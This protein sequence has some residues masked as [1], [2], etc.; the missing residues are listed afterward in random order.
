MHRPKLIL[1]L[2]VSSALVG[3]CSDPTSPHA[4]AGG[5]QPLAALVDSRSGGTQGFFFLPPLAP[6]PDDSGGF[7]AGRQPIVE[8]CRLDVS[9]SCIGLVA[10]FTTQSTGSE[11]IRVDSAAR[12]YHAQWNTANDLPLAN[13]RISVFEAGSQL[14]YADMALVKSIKESRAIP[15]DIKPLVRGSTLPIKFSLSA[16]SSNP[17]VRLEIHPSAFILTGAGDVEQLSVRAYDANG[18]MTNAPVTWSTSAP[19]AIG[20]SASGIATAA[21]SS[22]SAQIVAHSGTVSSAPALGVVMRPPEGAI[23]IGDANVVTTAVFANPFMMNSPAVPSIT[24]VDPSAPYGPGWRYVVRLTGVTP[25]IGKLLLS[26]GEAPVAGRIVSFV[27]AGSDFD[28]TVELVPIDAVFAS[29]SI[30][31][32]IPMNDIT[33]SSAASQSHG[34]SAFRGLETTLSSRRPLFVE[35]TIEFDIGPFECKITS[36]LPPVVPQL[37]SYS[38]HIDPDL[39]FTIDYQPGSGLRRLLVNG[40]IDAGLTVTP[41]IPLEVEQKAECSAQLATVHIPIGGPLALFVGGEVPVGV[42]FELVGKTTGAN[43][44]VDVGVTL[45]ATASIGVDCT[46]GCTPVGDIGGSWNGFVKPVLPSLTAS[47]RMELSGEAN[48]WAKLKLGNPFFES[49]QLGVLDAKLG[50]VQKFDLTTPET[51]VGDTTYAS[52]ARLTLEGEAKTTPSIQIIGD[53]LSIPLGERKVD[54]STALASTPRVTSFTI[55]P[56]A[57]DVGD[58]ATFTVRLD[59]VSYLGAYSVDSVALYR[60]KSTGSTFTLEAVANGCDGIAASSGQTEFICRAALPSS[61]IGTQ[62]VYAFVKARIFGVPIPVRLELS[63]NAKAQVTVTE[64]SV[65]LIVAPASVILGSGET[66]SFTATVTGLTSQS[67]VWTA[68]G[69]TIDA[70][71]VYTAG[72]TSGSYFV[73]AASIE[74]SSVA[75]TAFVSIDGTTS[76]AVTPD[77]AFVAPGGTIQYAAAIAGASNQSVT[78]SATGGTITSAGVYLA[79]MTPGTYVVTAASVAD[80][81]QRDSAVVTVVQPVAVRLVSKECSMTSGAIA[82]AFDVTR[83]FNDFTHAVAF[84]PFNPAHTS[85]LEAVSGSRQANASVNATASAS[86]I[87]DATTGF[88]T[89]VQSGGSASVNTSRVSDGFQ[90]DADAESNFRCEFV[91]D[92]G[93]TEV[94]MILS[95]SVSF[96][97]GGEIFPEEFIPSNSGDGFVVVY[98][99]SGFQYYLARSNVES[100]V[101]TRPVST[102]L[103]LG[104]HM[105]IAVSAGARNNCCQAPTT[106]MSA[107]ASANL[108]VVFFAAPP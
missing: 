31:E 32:T 45:G 33:R 71:G 86:L 36:T 79:G 48:A 62:D 44:G 11:R 17:A 64:D 58:T 51:Q 22:G 89:G 76:V 94:Y 108:N 72:S 23:L 80:P 10:R 15:G 101:G 14:G 91:F 60:K 9:G 81:A 52:S 107:S 105:V 26:T 69:G 47:G 70:A 59:S 4:A 13:Y 87:G 96:T 40:G 84:D 35:S 85:N 20:I 73:V 61:W 49:L 90:A 63:N 74:D 8:V 1:A 7:D 18:A 56:G 67:V 50:V 75:D 19:G 88:V 12:H 46:A 68:T 82:Q 65:S 104:G 77:S 41:V 27:S 99:N 57:V 30:N 54:F 29:L 5:S 16:G 78:W 55:S 83:I 92:P 100:G 98:N 34:F 103:P 106:S 43:I 39:S 66:Q 37:Q 2:L 97:R 28:V 6:A 53:L 95:G 24:P 21:T 3:S 102:I 42:G 25:E 93:N 38:F